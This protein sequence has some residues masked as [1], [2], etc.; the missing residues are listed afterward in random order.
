MTLHARAFAYGIARRPMLGAAFVLAALALTLSACG[1]GSGDAAGSP[2][3]VPSAEVLVDA[4]GKPITR[5]V[6]DHWSA[7]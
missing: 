5:A 7:V 1:S 6:L 3:A 4:H 2:N